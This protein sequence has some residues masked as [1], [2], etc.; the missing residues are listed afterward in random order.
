MK[1]QAKFK[2][3]LKGA[4]VLPLGLAVV[5]VLFS[6]LLGW[7]ILTSLLF[8][9]LLAP[10]I[11]IYLPAKVSGNRNHLPESVAGLLIFY[12]IMVFMIYD[13]YQSDYFQV[14]MAS[15]V[16]NLIAINLT[17]LPVRQNVQS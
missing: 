17:V 4:F 10:L 3:L 8:W 13:H 15:C 11:S 5:L 16:I 1:D 14:M 6:L 12:G 2:N 7:D 9:F